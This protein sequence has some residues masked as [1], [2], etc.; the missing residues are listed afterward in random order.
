[1]SAR[2]G[3]MQHKW[4][5]GAVSYLN[6]KPLIAGLDADDS[7]ELIYDVPAR[8]PS[9]LDADN[10]SASLQRDDFLQLELTRYF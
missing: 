4:K 7:I 10:K 1:M 8:L 2:V 6:T 5:L 3:R 9:L